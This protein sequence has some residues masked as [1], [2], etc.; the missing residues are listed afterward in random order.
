MKLCFLVG[1]MAI[2]GGTYVIVQ[3]AAYLRDHGFDV[4]LAVQEPF[5]ALTLAWHDEAPA[6]R[7][8]PIEEAKKE[9]FDLI[10]ATWW[11][12][13]FELGHF[14]AKQYAY[15]V[16]SIESNFY[17]EEEVPLRA[18][19]ETTYRFP[20]LYVT[21]ATWIQQYLAEKFGHAAV[22]VRNG[23][24]KDIYTPS[25]AAIAP[26]NLTRPPRVLVEGHFGVSFKNTALSIRLARESGARD[27]WVLTG[28]PVSWLPGVSRVFSQVPMIKTPQIYRSCDILVKLSTVEGMFGPPL[29]IFHCGGTAVVF[30]VTGHDEYIVD[31]VNACVVS[32]GDAD[33]VVSILRRLLSDRDT[34]SQLQQGALL[35]AAV[36]PSWEESSAQFHQWVEDCLQGSAP[37]RSV[38]VAMTEKAFADYSHD[39]QLRFAQNPAIIRRHKLSALASRFPPSVTRKVKQL[40]AI[41]EVVLGRRTAY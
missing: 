37:D 28:S 41:G 38:L 36:W 2:S 25:G 3:H 26:R 30:D 7:C 22:L 16:Q 39:E 23:I 15:F 24:R 11:K 40:E 20:I 12:T 35:T 19:V 6:L 18:L 27:I 8:I 1:S 5:S 33:G 9:Y 13:V 32:R 29:E 17:P 4:T 10:I 31:G 14:Q 21:E 34:L